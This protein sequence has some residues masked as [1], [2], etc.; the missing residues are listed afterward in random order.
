MK[1]MHLLPSLNFGPEWRRLLVLL[2][3]GVADDALVVSLFPA[4]P[5][6]TALDALGV[7]YS[8]L[9]RRRWFDLVPLLRLRRLLDAVRPDV[10]HA[11]GLT[12]LRSLAV[13]HRRYLPRTL[14]EVDGHPN[15]S[16]RRLLRRSAGALVRSDWAAN[17]LVRAGLPADRLRHLPP[18]PTLAP[19]EGAGT[20]PP[21]LPERF[22]FG[23]GRL[24]GPHGFRDAVWTLDMLAYALPDL[25][26]VLVGNGP[27]EGSLRRLAASVHNRCRTVFLT[28]DIPALPTLHRADFCW[29]TA[30]PGHGLQ[31]ALDA[32]AAGCPVIAYDQPTLRELV[33][34]NRTAFLIPPGDML[35]L[36][37]RTQAL[38]AD[39]DCR[40][41]MAWNAR[42]F[43]LRRFPLGST[44]AATR[45][46]YRRAG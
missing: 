34:E 40:R 20:L 15:W 36:A 33:Q 8:I 14:A 11:W 3:H 19:G 13:A 41:E 25:K 35:A 29:I 37:R 5:H 23:M 38:L 45:D 31:T 16:D 28:A 12:A 2:R 32:Q 17:T 26:L 44:L 22:L 42:D 9:H 43:T 10:V 6:Q 18:C 39:P 27:Q 30:Q 24:D 1:V 4:L 46:A 7:P 21:N